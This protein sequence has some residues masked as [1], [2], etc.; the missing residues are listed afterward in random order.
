MDGNLQRQ[1]QG[2]FEIINDLNQAL[3]IGRGADV[4][5]KILTQLVEYAN[6][7][8]AAEEALMEKYAFPSLPTHKVEYQ[9]FARNVAKYLD[10]FKSGKVGAPPALLFLPSIL[11]ERA[12]PQERQGL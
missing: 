11:A 4:M 6:M 3:D 10:D 2:L 5:D 8:F 7:H 9:A 12:H 1:H